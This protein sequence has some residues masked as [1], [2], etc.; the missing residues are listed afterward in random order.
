MPDP[1]GQQIAAVEEMHT[2]SFKK[3]PTIADLSI[4]TPAIRG[5][6]NEGL[7]LQGVIA[8]SSFKLSEENIALLQKRGDYGIFNESMIKKLFSNSSAD[9]EDV[10]EVVL[11]G[12]KLAPIHARIIGSDLLWI[13]LQRLDLSGNDIGEEGGKAIGNNITWANLEE[14][15]LISTE[16]GDETAKAIAN[17]Q[18]FQKLKKLQLAFNK[19]GD[20]GA[21]AIGK[22]EIWMS[23]EILDLRQNKI[24]AEGALAIGANNI[25]KKLVTLDLSSNQIS[26]KHILI[27]LCSNK[28]WEHLAIPLVGW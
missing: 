27:F 19:I 2:V 22:N 4:Q 13:N 23:L 16:I 25:W 11:I 24:K 28:T 6:N 3:F 20:I 18:K 15:I 17:N 1:D 21:E 14:L 8:N 9:S 26:D 10:R 12:E 7:N 5:T